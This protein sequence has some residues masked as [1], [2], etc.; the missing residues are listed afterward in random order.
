ML[1]TFKRITRSGWLAFKRQMGLSLATIFIITLTI[2]VVT[3]LFLFQQAAL[4]LLSA[5]EQKADVSIYFTKE[6]V[7][8][9]ILK[10][11][12]D[13]VKIPEL[14]EVRYVSHKEA[15]ENLL[16]RYPELVESVQE[17]EGLL[18]L[19]SLNIRAAEIA[20]YVKVLTFLEEAPFS[21]LI[22]KVDYYRREPI[23]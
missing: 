9:D 21:G 14:K 4:F 2:S 10:I 15:V 12:E 23:I 6:A 3:L 13:L 8:E 11:K 17:T 5:L 19:A 22:E 16:Q 20:Q 7:E 18:N 1:T